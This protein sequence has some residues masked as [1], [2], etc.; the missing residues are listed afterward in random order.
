MN[1]THAQRAC[2]LAQTGELGRWGAWRLRRHRAEC[3]ACRAFEADLGRLQA[4][5]GEQPAADHP[6]WME[7]ILNE[8]RRH[9]RRSER[10]L[11][12]SESWSVLFRPALVYG[13][14]ALL[15]IAGL[16][17]FLRGGPSNEGQAPSAGTER[18]V[19]AWETD[20]FAEE[21][22][23]VQ[24]LLEPSP[25]WADQ[26]RVSANDSDDIDAIAHEL[27]SLEENT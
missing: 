19:M 9:R 25:E 24:Y 11:G 4:L 10:R 17:P 2:L 18:L 12:R 6:V 15:L 23:R 26:E 13:G 14:L 8:A 27:L 20:A 1:C 16:Y 22:E 7:P 3:A 5:A 21:L